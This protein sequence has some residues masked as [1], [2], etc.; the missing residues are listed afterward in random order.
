M[1][2]RYTEFTSQG[3]RYRHSHIRRDGA[4]LV[5]IEQHGPQDA[6]LHQD[7]GGRIGKVRTGDG[8]FLV[9]DV[10]LAQWEA[11]A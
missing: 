3:R 10:P 11:A 2:D 5:R 9:A 7:K 6:P 4:P 1:S 8:W